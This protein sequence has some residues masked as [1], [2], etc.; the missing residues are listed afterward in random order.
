MTRQ[1]L[2]LALISA[3]IAVVALAGWRAG[4]GSVDATSLAQPT[5]VAIVDVERA[6]NKLTELT[7]MNKKLED[8][9]KVRQ[10]DL[11]QLRKQLEDL[12][13]KLDSAPENDLEGRR[14]LRA[15]I[16][17]LRETATAR[18]K[19]Y[20][21]LINIEKGEIIRPL[22]LK[23]TDAIKETAQKQ[24]Y[25]LVLFDDR[26]LQVPAD[27]ESIVNQAIQAKRLLFANDALD[28]TDQVVTLMNN[29]YG[30]AGK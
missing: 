10:A 25:D 30:V 6:L 14:T 11:D 13:E 21:S 22:Y 24:G 26:S 20:Q 27:T 18:T 1:T 2:K 23:L 8:R 19:A 28:I 17:E 7:D 12:Q 4:A 16:Y 5:T 3:S 15:Q 9:V 29:K